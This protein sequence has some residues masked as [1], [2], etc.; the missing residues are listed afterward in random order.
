MSLTDSQK[1]LNLKLLV[2]C[3]NPFKRKY[4]DAITGEAKEVL[5]PCGKCINCLHDYQDMW[6]IRLSETAKFY[7]QMVFDTL[8]I[9]PDN[10]QVIADFNIPTKD[11]TL[12]G[13]TERFAHWKV[14]SFK[15]KFSSFHR[16]WPAYSKSV[17]LLLRKN[18]FKVY[19]FP[20]EE[21]QK[22][23]KRGRIRYYRDKGKNADI[24]YFL[25][26]EYG[27]STSRPHFHLLMFGLSFADYQKYFGLPWSDSFG[28]NKPVHKYY[29][30][31]NQDEYCSIVRYVSKYCSKGCFESPFVLAGLQ[32]R[33]YRLISKGIG[34]NYLSNDKFKVFSSVDFTRFLSYSVPSKEVFERNLQLLLDAGRVQDA[35]Q[36]RKDYEEK[37]ALV[38]SV[39]RCRGLTSSLFSYLDLS[40]LTDEQIKSLQ[41]YYDSKGFPHKLPHYYLTKLFSNGKAEK[42]IL[43]FEISNVLQ[44]S[45]LVHDNQNIQ[46]VA[47]GLGIVI[48]DCWLE[49]D[50]SDWELLP[51][52]LF[53]VLNE[54]LLQQKRKA[55]SLAERRKI[56]LNNFY[57]RSSL[58]KGAPALL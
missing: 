21:V 7:K 51:G 37:R 18:G 53:M 20:K 25:V 6:C 56:R 28:F 40:T 49:T 2:N 4:F 1:K 29:T 36:F 43:Q 58:N 44:Q 3:L 17:W 47:L 42:N 31:F 38:D 46:R 13:S 9:R 57:T 26:K 55:Y 45:A 52:T 8:T 54:H 27:P 22:W 24:S 48:P 10:V 19:D 11:N 15:K 12:Y 33:P 23:L 41:I 50:S 16:Y 35:E 32:P 5:C 14:N 30:P 34:V 39:L